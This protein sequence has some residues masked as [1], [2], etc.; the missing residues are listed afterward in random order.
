MSC[1]KHQHPQPEAKVNDESLRPL[2]IIVSY[3]AGGV[4]LSGYLSSNFSAHSLM[5]NFMGG[6]FA[7]FS[8]FKMLD[9]SGFAA[10]YASYDLLAQRSRIW[11]LSYPFVE[12]A[13]SVAYFLDVWPTQVNA[14]TAALMIVGAAGV[15]RTLKRG[16]KI[17]CACLGTTLKLPMTKVTLIED[18]LMGVMA[19]YMLIA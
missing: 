10:G 6:F 14:L 11:A 1:G 2:A 13:L 15:Y 9:L 8:L 3:L 18:L 17:N 7:I 5:T 12:L 16:E 19:L 4:V